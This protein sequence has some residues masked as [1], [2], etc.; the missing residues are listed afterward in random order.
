MSSQASWNLLWE[1]LY[2]WSQTLERAASPAGWGFK[3]VAQLWDKKKYAHHQGC[4]L[5]GIF[6][7]PLFQVQ[8][9]CQLSS[10]KTV[11]VSHLHSWPKLIIITIKRCAQSQSLAILVTGLPKHQTLY[12]EAKTGF[13]RTFH[14]KVSIPEEWLRSRWKLNLPLYVFF[15]FW[16]SSLQ[17]KLPFLRKRV[18]RPEGLCWSK[19]CV[20]VMGLHWPFCAVHPLLKNNHCWFW[21]ICLELLMKT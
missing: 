20:M 21:S 14:W 17:N 5:K 4:H 2:R 15:S 8:N 16:F 19:L 9:L 12:H 11:C 7:T 1:L 13:E 6:C 10:F 3:H 18:C